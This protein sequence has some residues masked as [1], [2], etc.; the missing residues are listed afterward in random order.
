MK[1]MTLCYLK[2]DGKTLM[3]N[4]TKKDSI[5]TGFWNGLGGKFEEGETPEECVAREVLEESNLTIKDPVLKG[6]ITFT[7]IE[8]GSKNNGHVYVFV[9]TQFTGTI[10]NSTEGILEWIDDSKLNTLKRH[11]ADAVFSKWLSGDKFFSAKFTY[12]GEKLI[13]HKVNFY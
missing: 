5:S 6:R 7:D 12:Q 3:L 4:V 2:K 10:E 9:A 13:N 11:Q 1:L 8:K